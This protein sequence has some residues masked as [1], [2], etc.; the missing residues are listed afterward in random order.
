MIDAADVEWNIQHHGEERYQGGEA[1][2]HIVEWHNRGGAPSSWPIDEGLR[3]ALKVYRR[4]SNGKEQP[5]AAH[6]EDDAREE[7]GPSSRV[8]VRC[9]DRQPPHPAADA[10]EAAPRGVGA[11]HLPPLAPY[12]PQADKRCECTLRKLVASTLVHRAEPCPL[13]LSAWRRPHGTP[14]AAQGGQRAGHP[15]PRRLLRLHPHAAGCFPARGQ[16][17]KAGECLGRVGVCASA[18]VQW[19]PLL[20]KPAA[21]PHASV[22]H[23]CCSTTQRLL[24]PLY[25]YAMPAY[26]HGSLNRFLHRTC[27]GWVVIELGSAF[28]CL[29]QMWLS[30]GCLS[31]RLR[32]SLPQA[33]QGVCVLL[34][35]RQAGRWGWAGDCCTRRPVVCQT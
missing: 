19:G 24:Q 10:A 23:T 11:H 27:A 16:R 17:A 22:Q 13:S 4:R 29:M 20:C 28:A 7:G 26:Q 25:G 35:R 3:V 32:V 2:V 21:V 1:V 15:A 31:M 33:G 18:C 8:G 12:P 5:K 6:N 34:R 14:H 9:S 30:K